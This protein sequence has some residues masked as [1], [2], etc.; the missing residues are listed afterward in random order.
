MSPIETA[1][2]V[3]TI[4]LAVAGCVVAIGTLQVLEREDA[5]DRRRAGQ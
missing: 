4:L 5:E 1:V 3:V 2:V